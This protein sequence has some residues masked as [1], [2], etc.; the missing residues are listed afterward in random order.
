MHAGH[1]KAPFMSSNQEQLCEALPAIQEL[2]ASSSEG[3][4]M[5]REEAMSA[6]HD[7]VCR[8]EYVEALVTQSFGGESVPTSAAQARLHLNLDEEVSS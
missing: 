4:D 7:A 5:S 1:S 8:N 6:G 2:D 3:P